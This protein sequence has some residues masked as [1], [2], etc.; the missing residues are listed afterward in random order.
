MKKS[1]FTERQRRS[2]VA[3]YEKGDY[4]VEELCSKHQISPA[5]FYRWKDDLSTQSNTDKKRLKELEAE[6]ARLKRMFIEL[7]LEKDVISEALSEAKKFAARR[8]KL[9]S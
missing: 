5:T 9:K 7:Q 3:S 8:K 2:I 4:T 6:N 1:Q